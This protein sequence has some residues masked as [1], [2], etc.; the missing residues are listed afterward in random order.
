MSHSILADFLVVAS[1]L[2]LI[3]SKV[4]LPSL[5]LTEEEE[6]DIRGLEGRLKIYQEFKKAQVH[7]KGLWR[8]SPQMFFRNI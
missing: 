8:V 7:I 3:K 5:P 4:L 2:I 6:L 1:K